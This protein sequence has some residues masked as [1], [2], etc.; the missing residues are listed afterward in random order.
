MSTIS[1]SI[2]VYL[3]NEKEFDDEALDNATL[4]FLDAFGCIVNAASDTQAVKFALP[5]N[6]K[7][8]V[9]MHPFGLIA[10]LK[11]ELD[12]ARY[13]GTLV[14]WHDYNDTFLAKEWAHPSDN[15]GGLWA[16]VFRYI[17]EPTLKDILVGLVKS[18]EIQGS[19]A[20]GTSLNE[21][22]YDHVFY[23]KLATAAV[24]SSIMPSASEVTISRTINNVLNDGLNLRAY[25]HEPN[26]GRRKSWAAGDAT[27]R[28]LWLAEI[29]SYEDNDYSTVQSQVDWG[30]ESI[31]LNK[32][33]LSLGRLLEDWVIKNV[34]YKVSYPAE[35]HG[36]SAIEAGVFLHPLFKEKFNEIEKIIIETHEPAMRIISK[37]GPL[38]NESARDHC[39]EYMT[40]VALLDGNVTTHSYT[41]SYEKISEVESL[42][43]KFKIYENTKYTQYYYDIEK[44]YIPNKVYFQYKDGTISKQKEVLCPIGHPS[45][46]E[47]AFPRLKEK[48]V[49]NCTV[50]HS[51]DFAS[52]LWDQTVSGK[53]TEQPI[54]NF[55]EYILNNE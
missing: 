20:L 35:F 23:V 33:K 12:V 1:K 4:A 15:F 18:Y 55:V 32:K 31:F 50:F 27:S 52:E 19:L 46:R 42:R 17:E 25:R 36:Q 48:F 14:R 53:F 8:D 22:G 41:D 38:D 11:S 24:V 54:K 43:K 30:F 29:S 51:R 9:G 39:I 34:L 28:G 16:S 6:Y 7:Q 40:S 10:K 2:A 3:D 5:Y 26:V 13:L 21:S 47:E 49:N 44:R 37:S 45:R